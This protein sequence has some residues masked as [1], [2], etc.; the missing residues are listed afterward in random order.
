[1]KSIHAIPAALSAIA[2]ALAS[3]SAH[4]QV[5][6]GSFNGLGGWS[7]LGD[8]ASSA[9][10]GNHL[11]LTDAYPGGVD[12]ADGIDRNVSGNAPAPT[13]GGPGSLE[14]FVGIAAGALDA[15]ATEQSYEGSAAVQTFTAA[16]GSQ[17]SF[18][19]NLATAEAPDPRTPDAAFVVID[20]LLVTLG[21]TDSANQASSGGNY[22]AQTGWASWSTTLTGS[23][24]HTIAFGIVDIG[25]YTDSSAL[26]VT[27]VSATSAVPE[28]STL[29]L[30]GA[31]LALL[32]LK[33]RRRAA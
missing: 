29:A 4:A 31:G 11:V 7:T 2:L 1:M 24:P 21:T 14:D 20:G 3:G 8:A 12:D 6:N 13:G 22:L 23:G 9:V 16:A 10:G 27:G 26:L 5:G 25:S 19:W 15:G 18:Q 33:R 17:L 32:A 28:T 30:V